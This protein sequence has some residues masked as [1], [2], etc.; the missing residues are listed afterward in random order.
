MV[1]K[2]Y[3]LDL[4]PALA[5]KREQFVRIFADQRIVAGDLV[6]LSRL[7]TVTYENCKKLNGHLNSRRHLASLL[8]AKSG[9]VNV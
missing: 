7:V 8:S 5:D 6:K 3:I 2:C 4:F 9:S 1:R